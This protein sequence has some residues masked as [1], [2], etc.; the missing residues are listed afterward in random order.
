M[1]SEQRPA[2]AMP[3]Q[4]NIM[5]AFQCQHD[6]DM[7]L[8]FCF[9]L[10]LNIT[11]SRGCVYLGTFISHRGPKARD[12]RYWNA[13]CLSMSFSFHSVTRKRIAV[14]SRKCHGGGVLYSYGPEGRPYS[15]QRV[16]SSIRPFVTDYFC[17]RVVV[18]VR[19]S[20]ETTWPI[21]PMMIPINWENNVDV[22]CA[23]HFDPS[24]AAGQ[25]PEI[26]R[27][28]EFRCLT[29]SSLCS[30][31]LRLLSRFLQWWYQST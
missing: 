17:W 18:C 10:D 3:F 30:L 12:G 6:V 27:F 24:M 14:F 7:P 25:G 8:L 1:T 22:Q 13:V 26:L 15:D 29:G 31:L 28:C 11:C 4:K 5:H 20:S 21:S 16:R 9:D 19:F 2:K 23:L